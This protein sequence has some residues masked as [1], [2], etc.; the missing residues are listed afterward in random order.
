MVTLLMARI[1]EIA[2]QFA[3]LGGLADVALLLHEGRLHEAIT[4]AVIAS[5]CI[6]VLA[7]AGYLAKFILGKQPGGDVHLGVT[8][9][10][11]KGS[12]PK[13]PKTAPKVPHRRKPE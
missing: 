2:L 7:G 10:V 11:N 9:A 13:T 8:W 3:I 5:V 6:I 12:R 4:H 1:L